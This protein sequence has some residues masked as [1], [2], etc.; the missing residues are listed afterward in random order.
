MMT[1]YHSLIFDCPRQHSEKHSE[2]RC[3]IYL[4]EVCVGLVLVLA[5]LTI[6]TQSLF[7]LIDHRSD[8][9][10]Q[11][12]AVDTLLN[13]QEM[14]DLETLSGNSNDNDEKLKPLKNMVAQS[15]PDGKL[16]V[17]KLDEPAIKNVTFFRI[18]IS[19]DN[20]QN[21]P[22]R[23]LPLVRAVDSTPVNSTSTTSADS[24][25]AVTQ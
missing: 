6:F 8:Q 25:P 10:L 1:K 24:T 23:E 15:L 9:K 5:A 14:I 20:G 13:V 21:R 16:T 18:T 7:Q 12:I 3:G 2:K 17:E 4:L 19:Y 22:R 11:Q